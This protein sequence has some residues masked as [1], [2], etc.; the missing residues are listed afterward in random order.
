MVAGTPAQVEAHAVRRQELVPH[1]V[2]G[3]RQPMVGRVV[4]VPEAGPGD[5]DGSQSDIRI[6]LV[7]LSQGGRVVPIAA[8]RS[9]AVAFVVNLVG[10]AVSFIEAYH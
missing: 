9:S 4:H 7:G 2:A 3:V 1:P 5:E 8:A 6:G 10:D